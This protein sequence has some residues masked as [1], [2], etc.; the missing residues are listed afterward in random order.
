MHS[1]VGSFSPYTVKQRRVEIVRGYCYRC[2]QC[3]FTCGIIMLITSSCFIIL[4]AIELNYIY[5][6]NGCNT[7][8][9]TE[10][11]SST[12]DIISI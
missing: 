7:I 12:T 2:M 5:H 4:C 9:T 3:S 6:F 11:E 1:M 10:N 8:N